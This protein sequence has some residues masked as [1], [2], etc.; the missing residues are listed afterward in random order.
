MKKLLEMLQASVRYY[1]YVFFLIKIFPLEIVLDIRILLKQ[2]CLFYTKKMVTGDPYM[3]R[4]FISRI[5]QAVSAM[6]LGRSLAVC[7]FDEH[8]NY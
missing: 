5:G 2:S 7:P 3:P 8:S 1:F 6:S 4:L